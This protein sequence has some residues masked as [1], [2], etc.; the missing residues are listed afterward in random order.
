[1]KLHQLAPFPLLLASLSASCQSHLPALILH[2][3]S[4]SAFNKAHHPFALRSSS[5]DLDPSSCSIAIADARANHRRYHFHH[6]AVTTPKAITIPGL[7]PGHVNLAIH[8]QDVGAQH[9]V[10]VYSLS[11]G[12][13]DMPVRLVNAQKQPIVGAHVTAR[14]GAISQQH[15]TNA[16]GLVTL[17]NLPAQSIQL[18]VTL[19]GHQRFQSITVE[20]EPSLHQVEINS[21]S[22]RNPA[23]ASGVL[24]SPMRQP[25]CQDPPPTCDFYIK[26]AEQTLHCG[27]HGYPLQ[28]GNNMCH[29]FQS[30]LQH[31]SA[32]G[33]KWISNTM[34]CLQ[35]ALVAPLE[36]DGA[37]CA[38]IQKT[39]F[40]SHAN[41]YIDS[42][43]CSLSLSDMM[44]LIV[45]INTNL[46][47]SDVMQQVVDTV[48]GCARNY[49]SEI[50]MQSRH[51]EA[52]AA[53]YT[54]AKA[55]SHRI[56]AFLLKRAARHLATKR[57]NGLLSNNG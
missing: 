31:Y 27:P 55:F 57:V 29:R 24:N 4:E 10:A 21:T 12:A 1:M 54:D 50:A 44:Q 42:G 19:P 2:R 34:S 52:K 17:T 36:Q 43:V 49:L 7:S 40:A 22:P 8:C 35:R 48:K 3:A 13:I 11:I 5:F 46:L 23:T 9:V 26:C 15:T 25:D 47:T 30:Q 6:H 14:L 20:A 39:A 56:D 32:A 38:S 18:F 51:L 53:A 28:W 33:R 37:T 16:S 45:T 41:C